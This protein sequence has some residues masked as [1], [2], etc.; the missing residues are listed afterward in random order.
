M[1]KVSKLNGTGG[2]TSN[3]FFFAF[4]GKPVDQFEWP[5][6]DGDPAANLGDVFVLT[7]RAEV[8]KVVEDE[9]KDGHRRTVGFKVLDATLREMLA[10]ADG[11]DPGQ[12]SLDS[13]DDDTTDEENTQ[14]GD[15]EAPGYGAPFQAP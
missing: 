5:H 9:V 7:I 6:H 8:S 4:S 2:T 10:T 1:S 11:H 14:Y 15:Y 12:M 13:L 3:M